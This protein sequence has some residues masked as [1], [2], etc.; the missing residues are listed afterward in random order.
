MQNIITYPANF[1]RVASMK[2]CPVASAMILSKRAVVRRGPS[3]ATTRRSAG[4]SWDRIDIHIELLNIHYDKLAAKRNMEDLRLIRARVQVVR[5][6]QLER[7]QGT[8]LTC[9]A[10]MGPTEVRTFCQ[11]GASGK[12]LL[13]AAV[14]QLHLS[15][16]MYYRVLKLARTIAD[17]EGNELIVAN[18]VAEAIQY[19]PRVGI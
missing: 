2:P 9:N 13:K 3:P 14:Q 10:E 4:L 7:F 8:K 15:V 11:T 18:Y 5:E 1:M 6:R 12:K 16:K 19:R 17:L